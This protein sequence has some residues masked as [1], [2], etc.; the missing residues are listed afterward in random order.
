[1]PKVVDA[2]EQR[3]QI[4]AAARR[5]FARQGGTGSS[6]ARVA[7][8]AGVSR[9][10]LYHYYEDKAAL[11]RDLARELL[12]EEEGLFR[13]ALL[14]EGSVVERIERLA[15][16]VVERFS[17]W[18]QV[19]GALL[20][21][22]LEDQRRVR[23]LLRGLR[24]DL[25]EILHRGQELGEIDPSLSAEATATLLIGMIDGLIIQAFLDSRALP[26]EPEMRDTLVAFLERVLRGGKGAG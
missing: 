2:A 20:Q 23:K 6:L 18:S 14:S 12:E 26:G 10:S 7:K 17:E 4:R 24:A 21:I 22:W 8:E 15:D 3:A 11:V 16:R 25:T 13:V 5:V 1:M 19:G 9:S